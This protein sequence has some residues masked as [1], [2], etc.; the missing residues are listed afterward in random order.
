[1]ES[2]LLKEWMNKGLK[3]S[4]DFEYYT[5]R[6]FAVVA[7]LRGQPPIIEY[8]CPECKHYEITNDVELEKSKN[9]KKFQRPKFKCSK[10]GKK[11]VIESLKK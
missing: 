3:I 10:C 9:G 7:K 5:K 1:M 8:E 4:T 11:Y 2:K 6:D